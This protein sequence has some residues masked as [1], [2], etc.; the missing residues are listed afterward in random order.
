MKLVL[1]GEAFCNSNARD[2]TVRCVYC[3]GMPFADNVSSCE[4]DLRLV[5][6]NNFCSE[7]CTIFRRGGGGSS[8]VNY[9]IGSVAVNEGFY[10]RSQRAIFVT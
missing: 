4:C 3:V 1:S 7:C 5:I 9:C 8:L 6:A 10:K 2:D